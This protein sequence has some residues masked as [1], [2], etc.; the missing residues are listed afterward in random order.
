[1]LLTSEQLASNQN[2]GPISLGARAV[3]VDIVSVHLREHD[4]RV[5][6]S[7]KHPD[8]ISI[9]SNINVSNKLSALPILN[10]TIKDL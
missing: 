2:T 5:F 9:T 8:L 10:I 1:V 4:A 6:S 7:N 3:L